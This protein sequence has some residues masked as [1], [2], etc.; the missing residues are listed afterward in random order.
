MNGWERAEWQ[1]Q[2]QRIYDQYERL[3]RPIALSLKANLHP[4]SNW[5]I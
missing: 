5:T 1:K 4:R 2:R 3:V